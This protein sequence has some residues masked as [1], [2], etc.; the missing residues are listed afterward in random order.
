MTLPNETL[1]ALY[2]DML[3]TRQVELRIDALYLD[4][5]MKTPI[6]SYIGQEAIAAGV[7][8]HLT[9]RDPMFTTYRSHGQY[10]SKGG[11]LNAMIAE[12]HCKATGCSGGYGGSMHLIDLAAGHYGS[13]AI[14]ASVVPIATGMALAQKMKN[15]GAIATVFFGDGATDEGVFYE[16]VNFAMLKQLPILYVLEDNGWAVCSP[17]SARKVGENLYHRAGPDLIFT[18]TVDGNDV[19]AVYEVAREAIE[20]IRAT[21]YPALIECDT[22]RTRPHNGCGY[23]FKLGFRD[24]AEVREWEA[25]DPIPAFETILIEQNVMTRADMDA[26]LAEIEAEVDEAFAF[27]EASPLPDSSKLLANVY[28]A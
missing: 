16:S 15:T 27:A 1:R 21:G 6:H 26:L 8:A 12:L 20:H 11:D 9:T 14:V 5:H 17:T 19:L 18:R 10:L 13:S 7:C 23:D 25:K 2:R 28:R 3:R 4:D 24:E 22:Y